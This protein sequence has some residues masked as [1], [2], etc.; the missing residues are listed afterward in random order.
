ML[1]LEG[2]LEVEEYLSSTCVFVRIGLTR[3]LKLKLKGGFFM[4]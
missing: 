1:N 3:K 2:I 4:K